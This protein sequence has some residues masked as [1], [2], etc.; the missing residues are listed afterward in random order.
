[1]ARR[2]LI[3]SDLQATEGEERLRANPAIP[4][5]R[6][7]VERFYADL[8]TLAKAN[9]ARYL[10]DLGDTTDD[11]KALPVP[12]INAVM[13]G[14]SVVNH[15]P[16]HSIK[17]IG[18]HEQAYRDAT[19]HPG[20]MYGQF[21]GHVIVDTGVI[22]MGN[23]VIICMSFPN[24][25]EL[26]AEWLA[27]TVRYWKHEVATADR[28]DP[29]VLVLGHLPVVGAVNNGRTLPGGIHR[30]NF[31]DADLVLLG[32]VHQPQIISDNALYIGSPFQQD[33]G[34]CG[35]DKF[36]GLLDLDTLEFNW[37]PLPSPF[38]RYLRL[39]VDELECLD[40]L[41]EDRAQVVLRTADEARRFHACPL[42]PLVEP[43][44]QLA[45]IESEKGAQISDMPRVD[46]VEEWVDKKPLAG[47][48]RDELLEAGRKL[49]R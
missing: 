21:F 40:S 19:Q 37:L 7:R 13:S 46:W 23:T 41:G 4:L 22:E 9:D 10:I 28:P 39:T 36:V 27:S 14:L 42:A 12:T 32:H 8:A 31:K 16:E 5:Q 20:L 1:M 30:D 35:Q 29:L 2:F 26:A 3:F 48:T 45:P 24:D 34:E 15:N 33:F 11:R 47:F 49:T 18:N 44:Y 6:W 25:E 17:L 38:P 43:D